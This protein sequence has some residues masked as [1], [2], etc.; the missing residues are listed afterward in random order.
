MIPENKAGIVKKDGINMEKKG[1]INEKSKKW[2]NVRFFDKTENRW[3]NR[4][5]NRGN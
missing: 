1:L 5:R 3:H 4:V 2:K